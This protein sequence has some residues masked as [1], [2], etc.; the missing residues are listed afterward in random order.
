[1][2]P[3]EQRL[4]ADLF[5]QIKIIQLSCEPTDE[6]LLMFYAEVHNHL[7]EVAS[8]SINKNVDFFAPE[9]GFAE[10]F[11]PE[12]AE[13]LPVL[14]PQTKNISY[15]IVEFVG[16]PGEPRLQ[17][18][19]RHDNLYCVGFRVLSA[20][21]NAKTKD[22]SSF[23]DVNL[24]KCAAFPNVEASRLSESYKSSKSVR[25]YPMV[26]RRIYMYFSKYTCNSAVAVGELLKD[27][28][29]V[30]ICEA[31]R[32]G[33]VQ[34]LTFQGM[35][36]FE[37]PV[38]LTDL[39]DNIIHD[40]KDLSLGALLIYLYDLEEKLSVAERSRYQ[41]EDQLAAAL[42]GFNSYAL[43][44][45]LRGSDGLYAPMFDSEVVRLIHMRLRNF[46]K[47]IRKLTDVSY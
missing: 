45:N 2:A 21:D 44:V 26:F 32:F 40:Y 19:V 47:N 38:G 43:H 42:V 13:G 10:G 36:A 22:W 17:F 37:V 46:D 29:F 30:V 41:T 33:F 16:G 1:M 34:R 20:N 14:R 7:L 8:L 35:H 31:S 24:L 12:I 25:I 4:H 9:E 28:L 11:V 15:F 23:G 5:K 3:K 27:T 39:M 18:A 6:E